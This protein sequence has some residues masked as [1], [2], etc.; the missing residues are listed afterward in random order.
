MTRLVFIRSPELEEA[1]R[2]LVRLL[3]LSYVDASRIYG[4]VSKGSRSTAYARIWGLPSPFV[5][6]GLCEP[7]Y[8]VELVYENVAGLTCNKLLEVLV[9]ELL[10]IPRSFSGGLRSHGEWSKGSKIR[11]L[12]RGLPPAERR[13]LCSL[14]KDALR[15]AGTHGQGVGS[16]RA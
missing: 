3:G 11:E 1:L 15:G 8:V 12:V 2:T 7:M 16:S 4:A 13:R 5:R 9:H 6:L 14:A 10:H